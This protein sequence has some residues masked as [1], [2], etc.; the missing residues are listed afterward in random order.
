MRLLAILIVLSVTSQADAQLFRRWN[1]APAK[2]CPGGVCPSAST[3]GVQWY[4]RDGLSPRDHVE[5]VH[6]MSTAGMTHQDVLQAQNDYHNR[7]GS[8]HPAKQQPTQPI[9]LPAQQFIPVVPPKPS[10]IPAWPTFP[11]KL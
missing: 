6:G 8:G 7:Y 1:S 10:Q 9:P 4:S 3:S 5:R 11:P 2:I